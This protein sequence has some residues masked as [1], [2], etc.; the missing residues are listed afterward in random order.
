MLSFIS[1][2]LVFELILT[3]SVSLL[4]LLVGGGVGLLVELHDQLVPDGFLFALQLLV[5][6]VLLDLTR[7]KILSEGGR[8]K[9]SEGVRGIKEGRRRVRAR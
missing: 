6:L 8:K 9:G 3:F 1:Q 2:T 4:E 5:I 7:Y